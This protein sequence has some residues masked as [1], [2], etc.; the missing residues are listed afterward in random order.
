MY[1]NRSLCEGERKVP[2]FPAPSVPSLAA[3]LAGL[4]DSALAKLLLNVALHA[5]TNVYDDP[6]LAKA[7]AVYREGVMFGLITG[8]CSPENIARFFGMDEKDYL[9]SCDAAKREAIAGAVLP[10]EQASAAMMWQVD[11]LIKPGVLP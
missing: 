5:F 11:H 9:N 1:C 6:A 10:F 8:K 4:E 3:Q 2:P 7:L